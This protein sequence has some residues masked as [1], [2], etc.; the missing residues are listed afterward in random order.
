MTQKAFMDWLKKIN[1]RLFKKL[2]SREYIQGR[3]NPHFKQIRFNSENYICL[4]TPS[5]S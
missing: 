4:D 5:P 1:Y 2:I 3:Y